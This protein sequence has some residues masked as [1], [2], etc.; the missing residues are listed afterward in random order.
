MPV[1]QKIAPCSWFDGQA[2][3]AANLYTTIFRNSR[4]V[5]RLSVRRRR[6]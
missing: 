5:T 4:T 1:V 2:E 3:E 6:T